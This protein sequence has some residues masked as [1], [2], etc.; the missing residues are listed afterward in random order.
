MQT[1]SPSAARWHVGP[2]IDTLAYGWSWLPALLLLL[3]FGDTYPN[4][5]LVPFALLVGFSFAHRHAT[6]P[7]VYLDRDIF[8]S[9]PYAFTLLPGGLFVGFLASA[10]FY[11]T[12]WAPYSLGPA[13]AVVAL[14]IPLLVLQ[15]WGALSDGHAFRAI[16]LVL[17]ALP[18][19]LGLLGPWGAAVG[20]LGASAL[21]AWD[22]RAARA[23][24][25]PVLLAV[26]A[27]A[28]TAIGLRW[29]AQPL[30]A[31]QAIEGVALFAGAWNVWHVL[32]QKYGIFRMYA[33][34]AG[35]KGAP[36]WVDRLLLWGTLPL[37][38]VGAAH[39]AQAVIDRVG[40]ELALL[41][42]LVD[43][44]SGS[45][46]V[47]GLAALVAF[48]S[49]GTFV[50]HERHHPSRPRAIMALGVLALHSAFVFF[51]PVK[52]YV[53][54]ATSHAAEYLVFLWAFQR[55]RYAEPLP[56]DPLM[57]RIVARHHGLYWVALVL[58]CTAVYV[59]GYH[60]DDFWL[61]R[62]WKVAGLELWRWVFLWGLW[63]SMSHFAWDGFLWKMRRASTRASL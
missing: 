1:A 8:A 46:V 33:A 39:G 38:A 30:S 44:L 52:V 50:A 21:L 37:A 58:G 63:Q 47:A 45:P 15:L 23:W 28:I 61:E 17:A 48:G 16:A 4:D 19:A 20:V 22:Q 54:Y 62:P 10:W 56:H 43:V 13:H 5:Y 35:G 9:A 3:P 6:I 57:G 2:V 42:P 32:Q 24:L 14:G 40:A 59:V 51:D 26:A 49:V 12:T 36:P 25:A 31:L 11:G 60:S 7:Y 53:A 55:R 27:A 18:L 29:P 41:Q 34:K